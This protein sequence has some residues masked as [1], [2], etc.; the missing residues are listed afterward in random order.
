VAKLVESCYERVVQLHIDFH[1]NFHRLLGDGFVLVW[2]TDEFEGHDASH[3]DGSMNAL[4]SA[5]HAALEIHKK[6]SYLRKVFPFTT[7][8]GYGISIVLGVGYRIRLSTGLSH[9]DEDDY[10]GYPMILGARLQQLAGPSQ[11]VVDRSTVNMCLR[12]P[13]DLLWTNYPGSELEIVK[14]SK[15]TKRTA[16]QLTGL[17]TRDRNGFR[18]LRRK[19][20][21]GM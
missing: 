18:F 3:N 15:E 6:Y 19:G 21:R 8:L 5:I 14:P 1:H 12:Y 7:P 17:Q 10:V 20:P 2:E 16:I 11:I 13:K 4:G 9:L